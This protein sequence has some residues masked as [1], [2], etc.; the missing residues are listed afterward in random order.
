[1]RAGEQNTQ[2]SH[3]VSVHWLWGLPMFIGLPLLLGL[4]AMLH[5]QWRFNRTALRT[6]GEI[7]S[8]ELQ[9]YRNKEGE[10]EIYCATVAYRVANLDYRIS[11]GGCSNPAGYDIGDLVPVLYQPD[12]PANARVDSFLRLGLFPLL[13]AL[14]GGL[15]TLLGAA[16]IV[17]HLKGKF[18][19]H[20]RRRKHR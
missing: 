13:L 12:D 16:V 14:I 10:R 19:T 3:D 18:R 7:S 8:I 9:R 15:F 11:A 5:S 17:W 2:D 4:G 1:M 6:Q 20:R